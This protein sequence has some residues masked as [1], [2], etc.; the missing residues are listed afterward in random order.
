RPDGL[1][2]F[3]RP[4]GQLLA[5]DFEGERRILQLRILGSEALHELLGL[6]ESR[7]RHEGTAGDQE[8][9]PQDDE[10]GG[11][12]RSGSLD[13][14]VPTPF[15]TTNATAWREKGALEGPVGFDRPRGRLAIT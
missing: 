3:A 14:D 4:L 2:V 8:G 9:G 10:G 12:G 11:Q 7:L 6:V 13:H 1:A 15:G 5:L